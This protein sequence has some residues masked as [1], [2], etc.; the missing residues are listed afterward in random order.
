MV[1]VILMG[2]VIAMLVVFLLAIARKNE[3]LNA[4]LSVSTAD[5]MDLVGKVVLL[6]DQNKELSER[7]EEL[8]SRDIV[9]WEA[10]LKKRE[11]DLEEA[12]KAN[13]KYTEELMAKITEALDGNPM[14][15]YPDNP[16]FPGATAINV[17]YS[18]ESDD[19]TKII[20]RGKTVYEPEKSRQILNT[21]DPQRRASIAIRSLQVQGI[22]ERLARLLLNSPAVC[23][24]FGTEVDPEIKEP[25]V[26]AL[27]QVEAI[28]H[29]DTV[30]FNLD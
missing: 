15:G 5:N 30:V 2:I 17:S 16:P 13:R 8:A 20:I 3:V 6:Q 23:Y 18:Q 22:G 9:K 27:Y 25:D 28:L 11:E 4:E 1:P 26:Y 14:W 24:T 21:T 19:S 10:D 7:V 29:G 12:I